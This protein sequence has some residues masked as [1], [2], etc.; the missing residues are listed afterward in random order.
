M[1]K[2]SLLVQS[3]VI[4]AIIVIAAFSRLIPHTFNLTPVGAI[5]LF[6]GAYLGANW[7][8]FVI[9]LA[10][11]YL[12]DLILNNVVYAAPGAS[13]SFFYPGAAWV[14]ASYLAI[15]VLGILWLRKVNVFRVA[16]G[17]LGASVIFFL[18]SNFAC[19]PGTVP[20]TYSPDLNGLMDCYIAGLPFFKYTLAG[21]LFFSFVLFGTFALLKLRFFNWDKK[22]GMNVVRP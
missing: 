2:K 14:Y 22:A 20:P 4:V 6:G 3:I 17:A 10:A 13:F 5:A 15:V 9:P 21:D 8:S 12:S 18:L 7:K 11:I 16:T 19:W 1:S